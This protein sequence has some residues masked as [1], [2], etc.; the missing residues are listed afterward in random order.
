MQNLIPF[1][2]SDETVLSLKSHVL[3]RLAHFTG[4]YV[5][6]YLIRCNIASTVCLKITSFQNLTHK[7]WEK[8]WFWFTAI[9]LLHDLIFRFEYDLQCVPKWDNSSKI[10][11]FIWFFPPF[12]CP[13]LG[14]GGGR[15]NMCTEMAYPPDP[16]TSFTDSIHYIKQSFIL[17]WKGNTYY[18]KSI[19][20]F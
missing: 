15:K 6:T 7:I 10:M 1:T 12:Y 4:M 20:G 2:E 8:I 17:V 9:F 11:Y 18:Y 3:C 19:Q 5:L 14:P 16:F 13:V